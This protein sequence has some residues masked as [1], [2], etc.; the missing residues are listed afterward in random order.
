VAVVDPT[1]SRLTL[2]HAV[3]EVASGSLES[4]VVVGRPASILVEIPA[5]YEAAPPVADR[6]WVQVATQPVYRVGASNAQGWSEEVEHRERDLQRARRY[7]A[8]LHA[9][10][11]ESAN[12]HRSALGAAS[13][14]PAFRSLVALGAPATSEALRRLNGRRRPL[15]IYFLNSTV[16][17][18]PAAG[19]DTIDDAA[20]AWRGWGRTHHF[21]P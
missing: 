7:A 20:R 13:R 2:D 17:E 16:A 21:I 3:Y 8:S 15:W 4:P 12:A 9:D 10:A 1:E 6:Y 14:H 11:W 18:R 19:T 5:S